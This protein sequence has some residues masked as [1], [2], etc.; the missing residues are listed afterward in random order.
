MMLRYCHSDDFGLP[1]TS[2][3]VCTFWYIL[4]LQS[5]GEEEEARRLFTQLLA[6]RTRT[7]LLSEDVSLD[8]RNELWGNIPQTYSMVGIIM[9][10]LRLS[11]K[12][13]DVY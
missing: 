6:V 8:G 2:F 10:A 12:W 1:E 5:I 9:C 7:G 11:T 4:A 13:R 3:T